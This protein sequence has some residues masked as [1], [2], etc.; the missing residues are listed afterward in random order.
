[1]RRHAAGYAKATVVGLLLAAGLGMLPA[2]F[3]R[4][5]SVELLF[6]EYDPFSDTWSYGYRFSTGGS[7]SP[8]TSYWELT[9]LS[10]VIEA[11]AGAGVGQSWDVEQF[12]DTFV[13]YVYTGEEG[14]TGVFQTFDVVSLAP[15]GTVTWH[16]QPVTGE[17]PWEGNITGPVPEPATLGLSALGLVL[18][19]AALGRRERRP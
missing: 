18:F 12:A 3:S 11:A 6:H 10:G 16:S 17:S 1:M 8:G 15:P 2:Q 5:D 14:G 19:G 4:A 7:L 13:R 9:G